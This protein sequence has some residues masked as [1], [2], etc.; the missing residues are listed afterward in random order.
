MEAAGNLELWRMVRAKE[1][2]LGPW[3]EVRAI[4]ASRRNKQREERI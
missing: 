4:K 3:E 2:W 1:K